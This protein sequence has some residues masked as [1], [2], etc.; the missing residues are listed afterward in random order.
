MEIDMIQQVL[1]GQSWN[2]IARVLAACVAAVATA[3]LI[4]APASSS[5]A[6]AVDEANVRA[7]TVGDVVPNACTVT[8][9]TPYASSHLVWTGGTWSGCASPV[10]VQLRWAKPLGTVNLGVKSPA[11]SG[12]NYGWGCN[13]GTPQ[14]RNLYGR[15]VDNNGI[16]D[17]SQLRTF[18]SSTTDCKL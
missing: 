11:T 4:V 13:W 17:A 9:K 6:S 15:V 12:T 8:A 3:I 2:T 10:T 16:S 14:N 18:T 7:G 1:D 5:S